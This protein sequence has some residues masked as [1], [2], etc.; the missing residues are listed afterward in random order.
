M[1]APAIPV[2]WLVPMTTFFGWD[3]AGVEE[4]SDRIAS[5]ACVTVTGA[6]IVDSKSLPTGELPSP[7]TEKAAGDISTSVLTPRP[8]TSTGPNAAWMFTLLNG[9]DA[10]A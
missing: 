7:S 4:V 10:F 3:G 9:P 6:R 1:A 2:I 8:S 5:V